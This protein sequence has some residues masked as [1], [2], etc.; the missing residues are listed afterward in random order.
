MKDLSGIINEINKL[1]LEE[2]IAIYS[3]LGASL[4]KREKV[5]AVLERFKGRG[6][7]VWDEDAQEYVNRL[8]ADDRH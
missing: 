6:K 5:L 8:R 7:G 3:Q 2:R 4:S 1:S